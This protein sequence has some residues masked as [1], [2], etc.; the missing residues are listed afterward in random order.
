MTGEEF[1]D[2]GEEEGV[3]GVAERRSCESTERVREPGPEVRERKRETEDGF[4][5]MEPCEARRLRFLRGGC[6]C[7]CGCGCGCGC[8]CWATEAHEEDGDEET[9]GLSGSIEKG[10]KGP[11]HC[12]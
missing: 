7:G 5:R 9:T 3:E 4:L 10:G 8:D 11:W 2:G 6:R 12:K 1:G